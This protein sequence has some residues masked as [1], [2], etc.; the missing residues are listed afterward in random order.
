MEKSQ[1]KA[2]LVMANGY[3]L[4]IKIIR[5]GKE[6]E[7]IFI[8]ADDGLSL[9]SNMDEKN[10]S[11]YIEMVKQT[12]DQLYSGYEKNRESKEDDDEK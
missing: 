9:A 2:S 5:K 3:G 7:G 11:D 1:I 4:A 12:I 8:F 10:T 6:C